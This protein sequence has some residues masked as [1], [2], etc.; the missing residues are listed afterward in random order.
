MTDSTTPED[1]YEA[2]RRSREAK[3]KALKERLESEG[4]EDLVRRLD[5]C[6]QPIV[7]VCVGCG[8]P[9]T[10]FSRC[11][12]K[13]CPSCAPALATRT[14]NR[15]QSLVGEA[16]WPLFVTWTTKNYEEPSLKPLRRAW[17]KL[18]RL[19]W[20]RRQIVGGV[21]AFE[22]TNKG[23]G[24]HWHAHS[25][26]DCRWLS[27]SV[28]EPGPRVS[29]EQF[30]ARGR[31]AAKEVAQQWELCT[32]RPSSVKVRRVWK[33][34]DGDVTAACKEVLKYSVTAESLLA[35]PDPIAPYLRLLDGTRLVTSFGTFFGKGAK[36]EK[37]PPKMCQCGCDEVIPESLIPRTFNRP[38][39]AVTFR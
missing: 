2:A 19:R 23:K 33:R 31:M 28:P 16:A 35:S 25:L 38:T 32:G 21:T 17:G 34:D 29:S 27:V 12:I 6:G 4:A 30:K 22:C 5:K 39:R 26:V 1:A 14:V 13:W 8:D 36:R 24:W 3:R 37:R 10:S 20:F 11:D 9:R 15:Y 18:R 7:L